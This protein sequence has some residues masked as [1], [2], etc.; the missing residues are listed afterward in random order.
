[1]TSMRKKTRALIY[2]S[3]KIAVTMEIERVVAKMKTKI[4]VK[5][6]KGANSRN[7][8]THFSKQIVSISNES[9]SNFNI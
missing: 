4:I 6:K 8:Q 5:M 7:E 1:M 3:I 9:I 2:S